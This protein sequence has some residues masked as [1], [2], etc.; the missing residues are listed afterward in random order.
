L[1]PAGQGLRHAGEGRAGGAPATPGSRET[2]ARSQG[3]AE[4]RPKIGGPA[5]AG[6]PPRRGQRPPRPAPPSPD[7]RARRRIGGPPPPRRP[8]PP[9]PSRPE[10]IACGIRRLCTRD[11]A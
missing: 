11:L 6:E 4:T 7:G 9:P 3:D 1:R 5:E 10:Y 8:P 2:Q